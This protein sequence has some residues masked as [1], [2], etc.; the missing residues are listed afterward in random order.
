[1][2]EGMNIREFNKA[3]WDQKVRQGKKYTIPVSPEVIASARKGIWHII[4]TPT[5]PVPV[6]WFPPLSGLDVL[7]LASGGGMQGPV[8]AAAG[9]KVT[10]L[11]NSPLQLQQDRHV[12]E[13]DKLVI[14]TVEGDMA[15]LSMF[16]GASFDLIVHP[17]SN[18]FV[19]DVHPVWKEAFR[20]LRRGGVLLSGITSPVVYLFDWKL[21]DSTGILQVKYELPYSDEKD[22]GEEE[23][24]RLIEEK[25]PME[26]SHTLE[27]Q[28][29]GQIAAG[30]VITGFYEDYESEDDNNPLRNYMPAYIATRAL[31]P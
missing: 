9:A 4:L 18:T 10:V 3:A 27:D 22:L 19:P 17:V 21:A 29:G 8:L 7:C 14:R 11:D 13:R 15:D 12:A 24:K 6:E 30:F 26:F 1:M 5:R 28:I 25:Q 16:A 23:R 2:R 20:V 31:K